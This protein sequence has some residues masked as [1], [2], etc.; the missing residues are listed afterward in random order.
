MS[1]WLWFFQR[2]SSV[3]LI[4]VLLFHMVVLHYVDPSAE[5][6]LADTE[7]RLQ[8]VL[9][10]LVDSFLLAFALFHG[11]NGVRNVAYD[12]FPKPGTRKAL[13][14]LLLIVGLAVFVWGAFVLV[15]LVLAG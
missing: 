13:S 10:V 1:F 15:N 12:Y 8:S 4:V 14:I 3:G 7:L 2:I 11:L 5:I 9:F 6:T